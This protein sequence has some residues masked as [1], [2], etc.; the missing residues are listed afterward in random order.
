MW[1]DLKHGLDRDRRPVRT[2]KQHAVPRPQQ[3]NVAHPPAA[4]IGDRYEAVGLHQ[5]IEPARA[6]GQFAHEA[7]KGPQPEGRVEPAFR[8]HPRHNLRA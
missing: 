2:I 5:Q 7:S 4:H 1:I 3:V 6:F 8:D